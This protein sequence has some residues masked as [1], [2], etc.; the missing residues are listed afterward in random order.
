MTSLGRGDDYSAPQDSNN[1]ITQ[2]KSLN[3]ASLDLG[4]SQSPK[5]KND[6]QLQ[7]SLEELLVCQKCAKH[8]LVH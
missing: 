3:L 5:P 8:L 2:L 4:I 7:C 1:A 6:L